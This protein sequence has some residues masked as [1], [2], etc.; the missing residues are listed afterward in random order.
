MKKGIVLLIGALL[1]SSA[2]WGQSEDPEKPAV[3]LTEKAA[4]A[5]GD[6]AESARAAAQSLGSELS[7]SRERRAQGRVVAL[8][9]YS[10]IDLLIPSKK[11]LSVGWMKGADKTWELEYLQGSVAVPF[12]VKDLGEMSDERITLLGRSFMGSNSFNFSYGI[13]YL[14]FSIHLGNEF[15]NR[16]S[17]GGYPAID[18]LEIETMGFYL[19]LGNRWTF[20]KNIT[21]GVDWITWT[22]PVNLLKREAPYLT[23]ASDAGDRDT[24]DSA[25]G[26]ITYFPRLTLL[27]AQL[28]MQF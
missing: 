11:G 9:D 8:L 5:A 23:Y 22:Q 1:F 19:G 20:K 6:A 14:K 28:G 16:V 10:L 24:V 25:L 15:L 4:T 12:V 17:G 27:K 18:L 3:P 26:L 21:F 13:S 7:R 2:G